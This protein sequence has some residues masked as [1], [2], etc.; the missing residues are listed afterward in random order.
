MQITNYEQKSLVGIIAINCLF[1]LTACYYSVNIYIDQKML[2]H[3]LSDSFSIAQSISDEKD[4]GNMG[5]AIIYQGRM[6][7]RNASVLSRTGTIILA[8]GILIF[9]LSLV[10]ITYI[11]R[12][13][14]KFLRA[15]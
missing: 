9:I 12:L 6:L 1:V 2:A 14:R 10:N 8:F 3:E 7:E 13:R 5:K 15:N 11:L 4:L